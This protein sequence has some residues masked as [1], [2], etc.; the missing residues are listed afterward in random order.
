M[1]QVDYELII[2][3]ITAILETVETSEDR[4]A[5]ISFIDNEFCRVKEPNPDEE[6]TKKYN[7]LKP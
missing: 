3:H 1:K 6:I 2:K 7:T 4:E 5:F